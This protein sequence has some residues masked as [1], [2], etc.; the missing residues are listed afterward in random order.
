M[1]SVAAAYG[2]SSLLFPCQ[3]LSPSM[4]PQDP[5]WL[6]CPVTTAWRRLSV[7]TAL[8]KAA[9]LWRVLGSWPAASHPHA[10]AALPPQVKKSS[11]N[12]LML[13]MPKLVGGLRMSPNGLRKYRCRMPSC[14][15]LHEFLVGVL[16]PPSPCPLLAID[17]NH[18]IWFQLYR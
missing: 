7:R 17:H 3:L 1:P 5:A 10:P 9:L 15:S 2:L 4:P 14:P 6:F 12:N 18:N 16:M 8:S 13:Q 11:F